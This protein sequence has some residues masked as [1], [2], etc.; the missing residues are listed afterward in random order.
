MLVF[1]QDLTPD[2]CL[3]HP[4]LASAQVFLSRLIPLAV[5]HASEASS[6]SAADSSSELSPERPQYTDMLRGLLTDVPLEADMATSTAQALL[7]ELTKRCQ[8]D[9]SPQGG[10]QETAAALL[11]LLER[12]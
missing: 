12:R 9:V 3:Y 6:C 10:W 5:Q 1:S 2:L 7:T 4:I 11:G 8:H